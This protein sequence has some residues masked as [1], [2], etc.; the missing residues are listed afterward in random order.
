MTWRDIGTFAL[1]CLVE[2]LYQIGRPII[3]ILDRRSR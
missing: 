3:H 2:V 1:G